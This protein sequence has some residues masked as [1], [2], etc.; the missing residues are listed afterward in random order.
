MIEAMAPG[1]LERVLDWAAAE[2]WNPGLEDA[3]AFLPVD[4]AGFLIHRGL[5]GA[6]ARA[7]RPPAAAVS[8][9]NHT[10]DLAFLGLYI[11]HPDWRGQGLGWATWTAGLAHAG[12]RS[13]GLDGV[14]AQQ[15]NYAR[16]GFVATGR[17]LRHGGRIA[18]AH[19]QARCVAPPEQAALLARDRRLC[20]VARS[21]YLERWF[22]DSATRRTL[23]LETGGALQGYG[24]I[25]RCRS[26][27]KIGPFWAMDGGAARRLLGA[28]AAVFDAPHCQIDIPD[29]AVEMT[30][31]AEDLGL[32]PEFET[33]R[34]YRGTPPD[35]QTG[36]YQAIVTMELG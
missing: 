8:V 35:A 2:G 14:P 6:E 15:E 31:L 21:R 5:G 9:V 23:I 1:D 30:R 33:A 18:P 17:T 24:T 28:L 32:V 27:A 4:P 26:G 11:C 19:G 3:A 22:R 16:S 34:M 25:R 12:A 10:A 13:V 20:G 36:G 29:H 7:E